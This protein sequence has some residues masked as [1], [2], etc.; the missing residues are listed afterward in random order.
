MPVLTD[1]CWKTQIETDTT[2]NL[3]SDNVFVGI[4]QIGAEGDIPIHAVG[5]TTTS[6]EHQ[7]VREKRMFRRINS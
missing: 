7:L 6:A 4:V 2:C 1:V 3:N 5:L